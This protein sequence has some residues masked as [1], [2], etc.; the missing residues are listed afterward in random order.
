M[1]KPAKTIKVE[2]ERN[3]FWWLRW[4][5]AALLFLL[6]LE[7]VYIVGRVAIIPVL[8]S[9]A[10]AYLLEPIVERFEAHGL[11]RP[12]AAIL[13]IVVVAGA[14]TALIV[15]TIPELWKEATVAGE[16]IMQYATPENAAHY[17]GELR[18]FSPFLD[19]ILG[20]KLEYFIANPVDALSGSASWAAGGL[21]NFLA[22]ASLG[23]DLLVV[24][25]FIFYI[26]V[27]FQNWR[28]SSEGL[29]PPRFRDP[30]SRLFDEVGRI[31]QSYVRGQLLIAMIMGA[32]YAVGFVALGVPAWGGIASISG[33]LNLI[34]YVGTL[35]GWVL[36]SGFTFAD[37]RELWRVF[38]VTGIFVAVQCIEGYYL[39]PKILGGRLR[40]HPM[41]VFLGLLVGG[42]LFGF[43][44]I[45][46]AVP[47][48]AIAQVFVKFFREL[49]KASKFYHNDDVHPS[50]LP[51]DK[52]E[53]R[54]ADAAQTVLTEQVESQE[55]DEL[56]A[57]DKKDDDRVA[58]ELA[59]K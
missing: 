50:E 48:I 54:I 45:L 9:F 58:R 28:V 10:I 36:A 52:I 23:L 44:G 39:T 21:T 51:S 29:I 49:Y 4:V 6:V 38:A 56:M 12:L 55:G 47:V 42:K 25:F 26:L 31:L 14:F 5:P 30:F 18:R 59:A 8:A 13:A 22:T 2:E 19:A 57:P 34:P 17:R 27:D 1:A 3:P 53:E 16:R 43:L 35:F 20:S 40:L 37:T 11:S 32:L 33:F 24:P 15:L 46:L 7:L 41:A